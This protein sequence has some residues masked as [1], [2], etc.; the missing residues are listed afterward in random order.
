MLTISI[1]Q[2]NC[3]HKQKENGQ[4]QWVW[5]II[6]AVCDIHGPCQMIRS[7]LKQIFCRYRLMY[8]YELLRYLDAEICHHLGIFVVTTTDDRQNRLLNRLAHAY[9]IKSSMQVKLGQIQN[10]Q[11]RVITLIS[12]MNFCGQLARAFYATN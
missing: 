10:I 1:Y 12:S 11:E 6:D 8:T 3:A 5:L 4:D 2:A 9:G 7:T